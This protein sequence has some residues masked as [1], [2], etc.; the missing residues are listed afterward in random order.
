M[1]FSRAQI[2]FIKKTMPTK[3][4]KMMALFLKV[5]RSYM[6]PET[7]GPQKLPRAKEEVKRPETTAC[8]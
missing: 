7:V 8:T 3:A 4:C 2:T 5:I 6:I 1:L